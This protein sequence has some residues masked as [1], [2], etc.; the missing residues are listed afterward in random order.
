[1]DGTIEG[2]I[3]RKDEENDEGHV[4]MMGISFLD[5][6]KDLKNRQHLRERVGEFEEGLRMCA[7][8][9]ETGV[10]KKFV[11]PCINHLFIINKLLVFYF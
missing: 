1:M 8:V 10:K 6:V 4:D 5:M 11:I 2:I 7:G 9:S 3:L